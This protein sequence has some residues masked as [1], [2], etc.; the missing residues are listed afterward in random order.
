MLGLRPVENLTPNRHGPWDD[1]VLAIVLAGGYFDA[2]EFLMTEYDRD[3]DRIS[4]ALTE[5]YGLVSRRE[6]AGALQIMSESGLTLPQIAALHALR[7]GGPMSIGRL[8]EQI[9]LSASATSHLVD[10]LVEKGLV[11]RSEDPD[12]RRQKRVAVTE[13]GIDLVERLGQARHQE[14][15]RTVGALDPA[16]RADL[17][18]VLESAIQQLQIPG[19][20]SC[21]RPSKE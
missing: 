14:L 8:V 7:W 13:S 10:R 17:A 18:A 5:L 20:R 19:A 12:D 21:A 16:L 6:G 15:M 9:R 1:P 3:S 4:R 11:D 2:S